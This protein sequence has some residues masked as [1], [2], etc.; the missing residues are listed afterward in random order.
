[1]LLLT[2]GPVPTFILGE[3][4]SDNQQYQAERMKLIP[5]LQMF[6]VLHMYW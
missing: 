5:L 6:L 1:M 3:G 2:P 4:N